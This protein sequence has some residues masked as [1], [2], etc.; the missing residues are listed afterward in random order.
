M[1]PFIHGS[2]D[3][4]LLIPSDNHSKGDVV[5]A[6]IDGKRYVI[7]RIIGIRGD[8]ITLMGD[9][10][11]YE[12]EKCSVSDIFG[13]VE[14]IIRDGKIHNL[15]SPKSRFNAMIWRSLIPLRRLKV[16]ILNLIIRK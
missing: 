10:N 13:T 12:T 8:R 15:R 1:S 14:S 5:L 7:H 16:K 9:G 4:L 6:R 3:I 2:E 11:L